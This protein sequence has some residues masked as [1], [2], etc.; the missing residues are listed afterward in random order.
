M[1]LVEIRAFDRFAVVLFGLL[2]VLSDPKVIQPSR[3]KIVIVPSPP[4]CELSLL[5]VGVVEE[6]VLDQRMFNVGLG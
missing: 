6:A 2:L 5:Q 4:T 1:V 3:D